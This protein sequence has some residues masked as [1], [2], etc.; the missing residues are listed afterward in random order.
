MAGSSIQYDRFHCSASNLLWPSPACTG[1]RHQRHQSMRF[2]PTASACARP[3]TVDGE[4]LCHRRRSPTSIRPKIQENYRCRR[5]AFE[6]C[7][8]RN[9]C[10]LPHSFSA[11]DRKAGY[12]YALS[13]LQAELCPTQVTGRP[14]PNRMFFEDVIRENLDLGR[15]DE[16]QRLFERKIITTT[17][18]R[19]RTRV[20]TEGLTPFN[21][22]LLQEH[23]RQA[24]SR[25]MPRHLAA[26]TGT[27]VTVPPGRLSPLPSQ[28]AVAGAPRPRRP[29][30]SARCHRL[31]AACARPLRLRNI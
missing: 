15:P 20:V 2:C 25:R 3:E 9:L 31:P 30:E 19:F 5:G 16:V 24:V 14:V 8:R 12:R 13:I 7:G 29:A 11:A 6:P 10:D 1:A 4:R 28:A 27:S 23:Q 18:A 21:K 22:R 26:L 17:P